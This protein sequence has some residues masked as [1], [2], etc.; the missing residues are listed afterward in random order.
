MATPVS[1]RTVEE[2][3]IIL[4]HAKLNESELQNEIQA[5]VFSPN[6]SNQRVVLLELDDGLL[7][8]VLE[9]NNLVFRGDN[10]DHAVLCTNE[11][12]FIVKEAETSNSL[13]LFESLS[14]P[15]GVEMESRI[16]SREVRFYK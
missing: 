16:V 6:F 9:G 13:L 8:H 11:S 5:V 7:D 3:R 10:S 1:V 4:N 14:E 15:K 12:T 2:A